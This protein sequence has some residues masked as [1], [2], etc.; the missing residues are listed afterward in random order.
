MN[1]LTFFQYRKQIK[2]SENKNIK[3]Q[4]YDLILI[5]MKIKISNT[6]FKRSQS[7]L[8]TIKVFQVY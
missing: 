2:K 8:N 7:N 6:I 1:H 3:A 4:Q 5:E